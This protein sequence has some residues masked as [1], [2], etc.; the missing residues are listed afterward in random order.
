MFNLRLGNKEKFFVDGNVCKYF[1]YLG[2]SA[3]WQL[4]VGTG[5]GDF[6]K[7][8]MRFGFS[9]MQGKALLYANGNFNL[10]EQITLSANLGLG[11]T[12]HG[13]LGLGYMIPLKTKE[14]AV[15]IR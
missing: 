3:L 2:Y 7:H 5:F 9:S 12:I 8:N 4:G 15:P 14:K 10:D 1:P 13:S 6:E 11:N